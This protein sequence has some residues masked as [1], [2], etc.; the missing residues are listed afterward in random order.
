LVAPL[1]VS[2]GGGRT[3]RVRLKI[4]ELSSFRLKCNSS[5]WEKQS[6]I[7]FRVRLI[8]IAF[9]GD[10]APRAKMR[11]SLMRR[12]SVLFAFI[13]LDAGRTKYSSNLNHFGHN[14]LMQ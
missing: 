14:Y 9:T 7:R 1:L 6:I 2:V 8:I 11:K 13:V 12:V 10:F 5:V 3:Y 4:W